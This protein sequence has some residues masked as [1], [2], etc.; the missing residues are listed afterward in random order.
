VSQEKTDIKEMIELIQTLRGPQ[1]CPWDRKQTPRSIAVYL[2]EE[3]FELV[4]AIESGSSVEICEEL[5]DVLFQIL[6][7]IQL[8][9]RKGTFGLEQVSDAIVKKMIHR[10]PHVFGDAKID[11]PDAVREQW[12]RIKL[13]EKKHAM[14]PSLLDSVPVGLP[15][16]VRAYRISER[17]ARTGFDWDDIA[18]VMEKAKEEWSEFNEELIK[19]GTDGE[20]EHRLELEFGDILFTLVNVARFA[21]IHPETSLTGSIQKFGRRFKYM[22][23]KASSNG[24]EIES[25]S[26]EEMDRLWEEAKHATYGE[27]VRKN[28]KE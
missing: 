26:R 20:A 25:L 17:A 19:G 21:G 28:K 13:K 3:V 5:G 10:H 15:A 7:I 8:F 2:I 4:D 24:R 9:E 18:G 27:G 16:L 11:S 12:H 6:F 1:G 14:N 23:A 22:E